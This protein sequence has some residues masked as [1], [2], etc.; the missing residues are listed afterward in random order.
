MA[1]P[2][3]TPARPAAR[4]G[5]QSVSSARTGNIYTRHTQLYRVTTQDSVTMIDN[6]LFSWTNKYQKLNNEVLMNNCTNEK[7]LLI[8]EKNNTNIKIIKNIN[9]NANKI[10]DAKTLSASWFCPNMTRKQSEAA[11]K[12]CPVGS[13]IV[14]NSSS[15]DQER[16]RVLSVRSPGPGQVHHHLLLVSQGAQLVQ[17]AGSK[18]SFPSLF[19]LV[20]HLSIMKENLACRLLITAEDSDSETDNE[21]IIDIDSEP[22]LEEVVMQLKKFLSVQ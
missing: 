12:A 13:F 17:L 18:K 2:A 4:T 8:S 3:V 19:S 11:L 15:Q 22:E 1:R 6:K 7:K 5:T 21:D 20:T 16:S 14:R 10:V 9:A